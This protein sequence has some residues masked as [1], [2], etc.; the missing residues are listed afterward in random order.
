MMTNS[1]DKL[2]NIVKRLGS[3]RQSFGEDIIIA[4]ELMVKYQGEVHQAAKFN[5]EVILNA[6]MR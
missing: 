3:I 5:N 1:E 4:K 2:K 6:E